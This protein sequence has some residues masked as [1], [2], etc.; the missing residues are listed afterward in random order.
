MTELAFLDSHE[1]LRILAPG[2]KILIQEPKFEK[3]SLLSDLSVAATDIAACAE[4]GDIEQASLNPNRRTTAEQINESKA[5]K[6]ARGSTSQY[7]E[8]GGKTGI[9]GSG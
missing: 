8:K 6:T 4:A 3:A 1:A 5:A 7:V 2:A 9:A